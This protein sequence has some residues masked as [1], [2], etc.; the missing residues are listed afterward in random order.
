MLTVSSAGETPS[1]APASPAWAADAPSAAPRR[2]HVLLVDDEPVALQVWKRLL[3]L[4]GYRVTAVG[5]GAEALAKLAAEPFDLL[6]T[7][8]QMPG[9]RGADLAARAK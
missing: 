8:Q 4:L 7:D 5:G 6:V 9:L 1:V 2:A 3:P